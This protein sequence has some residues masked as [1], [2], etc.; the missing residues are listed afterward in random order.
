[1]RRWPKCRSAS[2]KKYIVYLLKLPGTLVNKYKFRIAYM[3]TLS[4]PL[5][6]L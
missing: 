6:L 2:H 3:H 1:M 4:I 5:H